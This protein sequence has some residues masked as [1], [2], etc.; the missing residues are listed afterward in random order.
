MITL[1][2]K[3]YQINILK[4]KGF[5]LFVKSA[6]VN[7]TNLMSVLEFSSKLNP[8]KIAVY[9]EGD[10]ITY[11]MLRHECNQLAIA[12]KSKFNLEPNQ[13][14]ALICRNNLQAIQS[15]YA[16]SRLGVHIYFFNTE[17]SKNQITDVVMN[18]KIDLVIYDD[19]LGSKTDSIIT[20]KLKTS[21]IQNLIKIADLNI[22]L[23][24]YKAGNLVILSGGTTGKPKS[25]KRKPSIGDF[26]NPLVALLSQL[27]LNKYKSVYIATPFFHGFG[28]ASLIMSILLG[29]EIHLLE[30]FDA[31]KACKLIDSNKVEVVTLVP[32]ML[33]RLMNEDLT[34]LNS[35]DRIICGGAKL[36]KELTKKTLDQLGDVLYN[37]YGTTEAGFS[38][39]ARPKLLKVNPLTVGR[40]I[41]GV[42]IKILNK[43]GVKL[44]INE[45]GQIHLSNS[46]IMNNSKLKWINTDDLGYLSKDGLVFLAGRID[47]MIISGGENVYPDE[48]ENILIEHHSIEDVAVVGVNDVDFGERLIAFIVLLNLVENT[49][50]INEWLKLRVARHQMPKKIIVLNELPR[51]PIGK[52][53]KKQLKFILN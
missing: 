47:N 37:L 22:K 40:P 42:S 33:K 29:S 2:K 48:V 5:Y 13:K 41:R 45:I 27:N 16:L 30:R 6:F 12:L 18:K 9:S 25:A 39:M 53:D 28:L 52:V 23:K 51:T 50:E 20:N 21:S 10:S 14:V 1:I 7:G 24:K 36:D 8:N 49:H 31:K 19:N 43:D 35:I 3:L 26:L 38:I 34:A 4:P 15:I 17:I 11:K 46:W 44:N 32:V